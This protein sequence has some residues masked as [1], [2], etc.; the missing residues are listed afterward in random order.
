MLVMK[1]CVVFVRRDSV[2]GLL[3]AIADMNM[4]IPESRE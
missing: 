3:D 2:D 1:L 4:K